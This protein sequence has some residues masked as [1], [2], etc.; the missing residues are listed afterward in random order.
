MEATGGELTISLEDVDLQP[1]DL[2]HE[3]KVQ[4]GR[5]VCISIADT[6]LGVAPEIMTKIFNPYFTTKEVGRG[7]GLGLSIVHGIATAAGG[8]VRCES[9]IGE[10]AVFR[11]YF[12][13]MPQGDS[14]Q[15]AIADA[16]FGGSERILL[17]DDE[18]ILAEMERTMLER[19]GY[20]VTVCTSSLKALELFQE[21]PEAFDAVITDQTM[22]GMTGVELARTLL[23]LRPGLPIILCTG[24]SSLI[25]EEQAR[26]HGIKGFAMKPLTNKELAQLL[27][28]VLAGGETGQQKKP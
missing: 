8:F 2:V 5:F 21:T 22:P 14:R 19:L 7:T 26:S 1:E 11:V 24:Y 16:D 9:T 6:G 18:E 4:P 15:P 13:A 3:H 20:R 23:A 25:N 10:G 17:I 28:Q 27:R 12:P